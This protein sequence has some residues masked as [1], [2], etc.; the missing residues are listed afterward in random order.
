MVLQSP[1]NAGSATF[2]L[3]TL[4]LFI[5]P[6]AFADATCDAAEQT[7]L[8]LE[9]DLQQLRADQ[10]QWQR[11][12]DGLVLPPDQLE[13]LLGYPLD[14]PH[15]GSLRK[16][17]PRTAVDSHCPEFQ[18]DVE[19]LTAQ[20]NQLEQ[21][22]HTMKLTLSGRPLDQRQAFLALSRLHETLQIIIDKPGSGPAIRDDAQ[23]LQDYISRI[24]AL[25]PK[26]DSAPGQS[27]ASLDQLRYNTPSLSPP[28]PVTP[29]FQ[30]VAHARQDIQQQVRLLRSEL[31]Q[32]RTLSSQ[33]RDM[34]GVNAI[35]ALLTREFHQ[36]VQH[37]SDVASLIR[38][39]LSGPLQTSNY[40]PLVR[41]LV[42]L[43]LGTVCFILLVRLAGRTRGWA[44][45]LHERVI[46][47]SGEKRWLR[48]ASRL[49][50]GLAPMLPWFLL[51]FALN[52][53]QPLLNTPS[54]RVLHWLLP[55]AYLYVIYGLLTL[56]GE[57]LI[58]RVAQSASTYLSAEQT[59]QILSHSRNTARWLM[60]IWFLVLAVWQILGPSLLYSILIVLL[61]IILFRALGHLL[62][63]RS[64]DYLLCLQAIL[65][66]HLDP[67]AERL[68]TP[69]LFWLFA[70]LLLPIALVSF[71][72]NFINQV[73]SDFDWYTRLKAR[74]FRL[75]T[76]IATEENDEEKSSSSDAPVK[77]NYERWFAQD[78][79]EGTTLPFINTGLVAAMEKNIQRW[80]ENRTDENSLVVAGGKGSG[81]TISI[82][83]LQ[84][85]LADSCSELEVKTLKVPA[86]TCEP[87]AI[88][89]LV[90]DAL[91]TDLS[92]HG[93]AALVKTDE[94]RKPVLLVLDDAQNFFL[95]RQGGLEGWR[96]VLSLVNAKLDHVFWLLM[97][98]SQSWAYL[99]NV[100][101]REYQFRNV[102]RVKHWG[103]SDI[104]SLI[105]SRNHLSG[106]QVRYDEVLLSSRGPEAGNVRNAEQRYFSL[107]WDACRGNPMVALR[108]WLT[109]IKV[110]GKHVTVGLPMPPAS[111]V[112]DTMGENALFVYAA[113]TTH[114]DL[115]SS[116]IS[117]V[118]CLPEN[119][120]RFALKGGQDAGFLQRAEDGRYRLVPLWYQP[121]I[122]YLTRK[123]LLNE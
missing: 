98:N 33:I 49:I 6:G 62:S 11:L 46:R 41:N 57:W 15:P 113:I 39:D 100:F 73:L 63:L 89:S 34:G 68:L 67:A 82:G 9:R 50:S 101:G 35:P 5:S 88:L 84:Q 111:G 26:L 114:G 20:L 75:R 118:T 12:L 37:F 92:E 38:L 80:H 23:T 3:L 53:L 78:V 61:A 103:Q 13:A 108:L 99:C 71:L 95:A 123:N 117:E 56:I 52:Q 121:V 1:R 122:S 94:N 27:L 44:L 10:D 91:G 60:P 105:L 28:S 29:A 14:Q 112:L 102:V 2:I 93:P 51:W 90:G 96:T 4:L 69:R 70:P 48:N 76:R 31:W 36:L 119:V 81:K 66:S 120:V 43:L 24:W 54:S 47:S 77:E 17:P 45:A 87:E 55:F 74:W 72:T 86:K 25:L 104:R 109:S 30:L 65:P 32:R 79:P 110:Q 22:I 64:K 106:Y 40:I 85:T 97:I 42:A 7:L 58:S 59:R 115:T 21:Q 116:E 8:E 16:P 18:D 19:S 107:L 83:K